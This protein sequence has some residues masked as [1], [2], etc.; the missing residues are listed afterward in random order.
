MMVMSMVG[1]F[2]GG[3]G[4]GGGARRSEMNEDR[5]DYLRYLGQLRE[6]AQ[7][8]ASRQRENLE[9][10]HPDPETLWSMCGTRRMWERRGHD[11]DFVHVRLGRGHQRLATRIVAPQSGPVDELEPVS[12]VALRRFVNTHSVVDDLPIAISLRGFAAVGCTGD[13]P[14]YRAMARALVGQLV[15]FHSPEDLMVAVVARGPARAEWEWTKWLPHAQHPEA[16][17]AVGPRRLF[18]ASLAE[19]ESSLSAQL[20]QRPRFVRDGVAPPGVP[21]LLV[22][23]DGAEVSG[24]ERMVE[25]DGLAGLTLLDLSGC[26]GPLIARRGLPLVVGPRDVGAVTGTGRFA[27][28]DGLSVEQAQALARSL[29]PFRARGRTGDDDADEPALGGFLEML[30]VVPAAD[31]YAAP[32]T[33]AID[34]DATNFDLSTAWR[35][36]PVRERLRVPIGIGE[37]GELVELDIKEAAQE[38]MGPHGLCIGATGSGKSEFL[39]TLVLGLIATHSP[40][41]LNLVLVD[42]KGGATFLGLDGAPHVAATITNLADDLS[43]VDRMHD[44]L[45]GEMTR[46]QELL[47]AAGNF[48]NVATYER[49]RDNGAELAPLPALFIVVDEFSELLAQKP[50][51]A[52]LFVA[53]GRLGRS[54]QMHLLLASQ[55][56]EEGKLR[57]LDSH[58]SYRIGLRTFSAA[59]SR[60]VL[61][62]PAAHELP[63]TPGAGYLKFDTSTMVRFTTAYVS[64]PYRAGAATLRDAAPI[65]PHRRPRLFLPEC[66]EPDPAPHVAGRGRADP[67]PEQAPGTAE[68]PGRERTL[69]DTVVDRVRGQG[70]PA[71][72]VWLPPLDSSPTLDQ[73]LGELVATG[74]R[75]LTAVGH[76]APGTLVAPVGVVDKPF[77]QRREKLV[78][79]LS[80]GQG[81]VAVVGGPRTGKSTLL[82]TLIMSL[83]LTHT[84]EQVQFYCLDLG[85]GTLSVL[86][87]LPHV[88]SVT[89][90][91]DA[92]RVRRTV[93]ELTAIVRGRER[94]FRDAGIDSMTEFRARRRAGEHAGTDAHGDVFLVIDG[95][96]SFR[97]EFEALEFPVTELAAQGLAYGV[98]VVLGASR[99][100]EV[101]PALKDL[102][103]TRVE[104]RLGDAAESEM[105]RRLAANVP[106]A[107]PGRGLSPERLHLLAALPRIDASPTAHDLAGAVA[108]AVERIDSAWTGRRAPRVRMLPERLT[109]TELRA[110]L[111]RAGTGPGRDGAGHD[112]TP[113]ARV[114]IGIDESELAPVHLDL[115][116]EPHLVVFADAE[117]GKTTLLRTICTELVERNS[118]Q[119]A[120]LLI[121][122]Y[123]RTMLGLVDTDHLAGYA[124]GPDSLATMIS[125]LRGL[126]MARLPGPDVTQGELRDRSWWSG[127]EVYVVVDDYD[128][129]AGAAVN[130]VAPLLDLL[131]Q[132]KDVGLHLILARR[133]GGASRALYEPVI[134]RLRDLAATGLVM[135]GSP[136]EGPLVGQARP[137][138]M[139]PGRGLLVSRRRSAE[140]VQLVWTPPS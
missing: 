50:D 61:G 85:G 111:V 74:D 24:E 104:L 96:A 41:D 18:F 129:V 127:P 82:R 120:K 75:G 124:A 37:H 19:L 138:S 100:A 78:V 54:L 113:G 79:D 72:E 15:T 137:S 77:E 132:A 98:H 10:V 13:E 7:D 92:D 29:A 33:A 133:S 76:P 2:A 118:P 49:A 34:L 125:D 130:P 102:I 140:L 131:A 32:G 45:S 47:R 4:R 67:A 28:P 14:T 27:T 117:S 9:W 103:D 12:T 110:A 31:P 94:R 1:M 43:M 107:R 8:A 23:L 84:P 119:Q 69:L 66:V 116:A 59:E 35:R 65:T 60:A 42:F 68:S 112:R 81:H 123:R 40:A 93:A 57:G 56:L 36:R 136:D 114:P 17:D 58:L 91:L 115:A 89:G 101:R 83:A 106:R 122:D 3:S 26:V 87:G 52:E 139:P 46:R 86:G 73:L 90:R 64:G 121:A 22:V 135:N 109:R 21:H 11:P 88:G 6:R 134:A 30:G 128:L 80:G 38:G 48:A 108:A 55:R 97:A 99:W 16:T 105:D 63:S 70:P 39:R 51:F 95:W 126:L 53:I 25:E 44:A 71:H 5:K 62:V 20:E